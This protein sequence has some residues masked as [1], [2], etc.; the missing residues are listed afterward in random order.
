MSNDTSGSNITIRPG[1][2]R[3]APKVLE[4]DIEDFDLDAVSGGESES[5]SGDED[6]SRDQTFQKK[7]VK[8]NMMPVKPAPKSKPLYV[9]L[10]EE[11]MP[12][13]LTSAQHALESSNHGAPMAQQVSQQVVGHEHQRQMS[14]RETSKGKVKARAFGKRK[15]RP[16][17]V[18]P[19]NGQTI[20]VH[21]HVRYA[22]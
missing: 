15:T 2:P 1:P 12:P 13:T 16:D 21:N 11:D 19:G 8:I 14:L 9:D 22:S 17:I 10:S 3:G 4:S 5:S 18:G 20:H 6:L 7:L